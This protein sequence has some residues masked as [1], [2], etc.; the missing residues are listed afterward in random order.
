MLGVKK[1]VLFLILKELKD[2]RKSLYS[3][4]L[5]K[6]IWCETTVP[7]LWKILGRYTLTENAKIILFDV[8]LSHLSKESRD[9]LKIQGI[10]IFN[11]EFKQPLFNY[12]S[13]WRYL[14]LF[15]LES[16]IISKKD[17]E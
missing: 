16:M 1:N 5:V 15:L 4:L 8:I 14:D 12:I 17:I 3:C 11:E 7:I 9:I 6:R 2:D 10:N 13:F